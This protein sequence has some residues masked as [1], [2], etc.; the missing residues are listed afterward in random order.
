ME[1]PMASEERDRKFDK[2]IARHLRSAGASGDAASKAADFVSHGDSCPDAET[3]AAYHERSL[4]PAELSAWKEHLV[5]CAHCQELLAHLESTDD[6]PLYAA[7][8]EELFTKMDTRPAS[9]ARRVAP[10]PMAAA[11]PS[12]SQRAARWRWL[13]PAAAMAAGLLVWIAMHE[14]PPRGSP[15][16]NEIKMAKN[17]EPP[18]SAPPLS[19]RVPPAERREQNA[20]PKPPPATDE[21]S[22]SSAGE[23]SKVKALE[24]R[25]MADSRARVSPAKPSSDKEN[26][27]R[28]DAGR[29][30]SGDLL[31]KRDQPE[32][33]AKIVGGEVQPKVEVQA[34][35]ANVQ[36]QNQNNASLPRIPGPAPLGQVGTSKKLK[37][38]PPPSPAPAPPASASPSFGY[39]TEMVVVSEP[40]LITVPGSNLFW[41]TGPAGLIEFSSDGGRSWSRQSSG[42]LVD[43]L[44][45]LALSD[46]TCWIVGRVGAILLTTDGGAHWKLISSPLKEDLGGIQATDA[47]HATV[48]SARGT[49]SFA[50]RDGGLTWEHVQRE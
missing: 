43:L 8:E 37:T 16:S 9:A 21:I 22:S 41:R 13:A 11:A 35:G 40:N 19:T 47:L 4:L 44:T 28:K 29:A 17:Q 5:G 14:T 2:A 7:E 48:W 12:R 25:Q 15:G 18:A 23:E 38:A 33:D 34:Q 10:L 1:K 20:L 32:L 26:G 42:V 24:Q 50:T 45:G 3:L 36:S 46:K 27:A 31:A 30:S 6:I 49:K 39:A